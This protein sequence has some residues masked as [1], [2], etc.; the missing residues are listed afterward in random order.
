MQFPLKFEDLITLEYF[1]I[2]LF[3]P[4]K[5][6]EP[7][8][9]SGKFS[10]PDPNT[11]GNPAFKVGERILR[12]T[13]DPANGVLSGDTETSGE[14]TYYAKGLL[15]NIQETIIATRNADVNR[16]TLNQERTVTSTR[17][18]DRQ[19]GWYD[20]VAQSIMIDEKGGAFITSVE[21][22][23]QSKSDIVPAVCQIRT[24]KGGYPTTTILPF[25][26][27][28]VEPENVNISEDAS[29]STKFTFPSPVYLQQDIEYCFVILANTQDYHIWLSHQ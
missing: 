15:D 13:S 5:S 20:P 17:S 19:T 10:I 26:K 29:V 23:F 11:S 18:S 1:V 4:L 7:P 24:M 21:V 14:A 2:V 22:Y 12:L 27:V 3:E 28:V 25:G 6:A 16:V 9:N 8:T